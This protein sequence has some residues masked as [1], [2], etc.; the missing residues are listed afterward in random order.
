MS[1]SNLFNRRLSLQVMT[2]LLVGATMPVGM[3]LAADVSPTKT[4]EANADTSYYF[5]LEDFLVTAERIPTNRWDTP[6]S[7]T[8]ITADEIEANH[9]RS[10]SEAISHVNGMTGQSFNRSDQILT[11]VDGRRSFILPSLKTVERIELVRDGGS[12]LYGS[13]ATGGVINIITKKGDKNETVVDVSAGSWKNQTYDIMNRG[14]DG[15]LDWLVDVHIDKG[16]LQHFRGPG[17][18]TYYELSSDRNNEGV[19][20]KL[21]HRFDERNSVTLDI[22]HLSQKYNTRKYLTDDGFEA[23]YF[24]LAN[25]ASVSFN[26]KEGTSTPGFLRFF[27]NYDSFLNWSGYD[28]KGNDRNV[29]IDYQNGWELGQH[30]IIAGL[31]YHKDRGNYEDFGSV[32]KSVTNRAYYLQDTIKLSDKWMFVPGV[33]LDHHST[34]GNQW[35]PKVAANYRADDKTKVHASWGKIFRA[36]TLT[37][38]YTDRARWG[39]ASD[40]NGQLHLVT[41]WFSGNRNLLP[42]SGQTATIGLEHEF[43]DNSRLDVNIFSNKI[44]NYIDLFDS[45]DGAYTTRYDYV[46]SG[47]NKNHGLEIF[48]KKVIDDNWN[49]DLGYAFLH[50]DTTLG[51]EMSLSH[52]VYPMHSGRV[53]L[54]YGNGPFKANLFGTFAKGHDGVLYLN[55]SLTLVDLN[56]SY[57]VSDKITLYAKGLNLTNRDYF[58]YH[59][60][61]Y[62]HSPGR[63]FMF[64]VDCKF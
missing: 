10:L 9:Y 33:R 23:D 25:Q 51:D 54:H 24:T 35:S 47:E 48:Y 8:I 7:I 41:I 22:Q 32:D 16:D 44:K 11:L 64:G 52:Q 58:N 20:A 14:N 63:F 62:S 18:A 42:Q 37:E 26:F 38:L 6:A 21:N 59:N 27:N 40:D 4:S 28:N 55:R 56:L 53:G 45:T 36:P 50:R 61:N 43:E 29:G 5:A 13:S 30:K 12:A 34:Y 15:R 3:A 60:Q 46:N 2:A 17:T 31:E 1:L 19:I 49:V 57:D 39:F